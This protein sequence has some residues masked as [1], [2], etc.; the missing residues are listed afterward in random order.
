MAFIMLLLVGISMLIS[1]KFDKGEQR[2]R[3]GGLW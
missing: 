2:V 3:G 1:R